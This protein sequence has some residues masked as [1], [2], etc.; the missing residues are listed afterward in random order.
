MPG[1]FQLRI[2]LFDTGCNHYSNPSTEK[3]FVSSL[4]CPKLL[5]ASH[6]LLSNGHRN[7]FP[8]GQRGRNVTLTIHPHVG[9]T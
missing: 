7:L 8:R 5:W 6:S 3:K 4:N 1:T 2:A 9:R